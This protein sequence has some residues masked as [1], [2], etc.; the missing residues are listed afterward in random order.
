MEAAGDDAAL[1][2]DQAS[3]AH[4]LIS[5][6]M[7]P[8]LRRL[9][10]P[11]FFYLFSMTVDLTEFTMITSTAVLFGKATLHMAPS[12]LVLVGVLAPSMGIAWSLAFPYIQR[13]L[14]WSNLRIVT[15]LALLVSCTC[16]RV[17]RVHSVS[18]AQSAIR[19]AHHFWRDVWPRDIL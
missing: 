8:P 16:V 17:F 3:T 1:E 12:W 4:V 7:V 11:P 9:A 6:R 5:Y 18:E 14:G 2:P 15:L 13:E 19:R 10:K